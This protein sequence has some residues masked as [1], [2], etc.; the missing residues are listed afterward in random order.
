MLLVGL[1]NVQCVLKCTIGNTKMYPTVTL[2]CDYN[3]FKNE[4]WL[5]WVYKNGKT[6]LCSNTLNS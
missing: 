3:A 6:L 5:L 1:I 2:K 4:M